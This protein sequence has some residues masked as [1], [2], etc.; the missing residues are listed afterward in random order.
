MNKFLSSAGVASRR[1]CDKL[2]FDGKIM[3][4]GVVAEGPFIA[5]DPQKD[6]VMYDEER[7][8]LQNKVYFMLHKPEGYLCSSQKKFLN[9]KL[10]IDLFAHLPYRVFTVGRLDKETTGLLLI[11]NDG[12]FANK[13]IHPSYGITK[14]YLLKVSQDVSDFQLKSFMNG[15]LIDGSIIKPV[16]VTKIRRGTLKVVV[17]EGKKHEVRL[18]AEIAG[19]NLLSLAR[20][21][22]G[23]LVLGGLPYGGYRELTTSEIDACLH[24]RD[25]IK[26]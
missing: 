17:G 1:G 26:R 18:L 2:I 10:V 25:R 19:L 24:N 7:V 16:S 8:I 12:D 13:I 4:N 14:E 21:R 20:I 6:V 3:V 11:T 9:D 15:G 22:I 23:S 5:V